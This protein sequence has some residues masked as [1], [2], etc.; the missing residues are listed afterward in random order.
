MRIR[1]PF[2]GFSHL[3]GLVLSIAGLGLLLYASIRYGT[4]RHIVAV[5]IFGVSLVLMYAASSLYHLLQLSEQG[6][7]ALKRLDH[8][9]IYVFI[10]G[11]Y[12]P[13]CLIALQGAWR[14][15]L[16]IPVWLIAGA[17]IVMKG[18]KLPI[19]RWL[20]TVLYLAMGWLAVVTVP[21]LLR[22][23]PI[24]ACIWLFAGGL[25]YTVGAAVYA[26]KWP[27]LRPGV[28]GFHELWHMFVLAGSASHFWFVY[29]YMAVVP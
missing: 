18:S 27:R 10:A 21:Q 8:M 4:A 22:V 25:F 7:A 23:M 26:A 16:L 15:G 6:V 24:A 2:N 9:M 13:L 11:S 29:R 12:T 14:W 19:P 5:V 3:A 28:F 20:S 1:E 17:G